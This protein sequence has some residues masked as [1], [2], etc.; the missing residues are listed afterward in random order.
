MLVFD[1]RGSVMFYLMCVHIIF[2]T[3]WIAEWPPFGKELVTRLRYV[4]FVLLL[5]FI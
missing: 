5:F 2:S 1:V 3:V 4:L